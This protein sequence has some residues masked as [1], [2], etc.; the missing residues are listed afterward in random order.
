MRFSPHLLDEIRARLPVSQ[1]VGRKVALKRKGR[2]YSG[3]S[4]FKVEKTPSFFVND[5]KGFYHCFASGEHGDIFTFL[6]KTEGVSFPEAVERLAEEAGV[7]LPKSDARDEAREDQRTR[8]LALMEESAKFFEVALAGS[9]G[10]EARRYIEKRG[11]KRETL[12]TFRIGYAP[13][14]RSA[15][16]EHLAKAGFTL[17]EMTLSGMLIAGDDI[18]VAYDRF[19]HRVM[20]PIGDAKGR[21]VAFGGRALDPDQ[22]AKY[23]NSPE[24]PLFHK[25]HLLFNAHRARAAAHDKQR[26][27]AVEGYMDAISLS[28]AGFTETVAPLGTALT[29]DQLQLLWRM[30]AEPILCFD[31]DSAGKR[32]AFRAVDTALPHLKPGASLMFAFLPDGLDPDDL[33]RQQ[34]PAALDAC[35][36]R[37]RPLIDVLFEREWGQGDWSTPERRAGL[38]KTLKGLIGRIADESVRAHYRQ[39]LGQRLTAAWAPTIGTGGQGSQAGVAGGGRW[40][41]APPWLR[42]GGRGLRNAGAPSNF[43]RGPAGRSFPPNLGQGAEHLNPSSSLRKSALVASEGGLP[44]YREALLLKVLLNHPWLIEEQAEAI[45]GLPFTS[46]ALSALRDAILSA[47]ALDNS[48]DTETLR[49][50]LNKSSVGK[51]LTLV[52]R[53]VSHK[54]DRFAE[55]EAGRTEVEDGW[56]HALAMHDR[57]V[58]LQRSLEAAEQAWHEDR[59]EASFARICDLKRQLELASGADS[60]DVAAGLGHTS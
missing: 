46:T 57:H 59:S 39:S 55:P 32:A 51:V 53:A 20:F 47:H 6:M 43:R 4:P 9:A 5:Q 13:N 42:G 10:G 16:K 1:V 50:H 52:E 26:V 21:I 15:L 17:E 23:L 11:L 34:G 45:A 40:G 12:A 49:T 38:E 30:S 56:R 54:C 2:E 48:L 28:E 35:L 31:G 33:V 18:P 29:E 36:G 14:S 22:N 41:T 19:R 58:G 27:I 8:L 60:F 37:A 25:G 44:P 24:T 3:L 7:A